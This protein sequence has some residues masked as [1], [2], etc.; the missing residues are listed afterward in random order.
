MDTTLPK[1]SLWRVLQ[2]DYPALL[3]ALAPVVCLGMSVVINVFGSLPALG[4]HSPIGPDGAPFFMWAAIV[5]AVVGW[6][7]AYWRAAKVRG[8]FA[9]GVA[10]EGRVDKVLFHRDRGSIN[11]TYRLDGKQYA[12]FNA[13]NLSKRSAAFQEGAP[14]ALVVDRQN[15]KVAYIRDLFV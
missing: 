8:V 4:R 11:F 1:P 7:F 2:A 6:P 15:P 5:S 3:A 13:V 12:G 9:R 10:V 14:V